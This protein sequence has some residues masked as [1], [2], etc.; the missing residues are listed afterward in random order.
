MKTRHKYNLLVGFTSLLTTLI[1]PTAVTANDAPPF[2]KVEAVQKKFPLISKTFYYEKT[3]ASSKVIDMRARKSVETYKHVKPVIHLGLVDT[4]AVIEPVQSKP[5][6]IAAKFDDKA[7]Q[8]DLN[9]NYSLDGLDGVY[10]GMPDRSEYEDEQIQ[11]HKLNFVRKAT[12]PEGRYTEPLYTV[13]G[14]GLKTEF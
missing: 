1:L 11:K 6:F 2:T 12:M 9:I 5:G 7:F 13:A 10:F 3:A 8:E 14:T 4:K